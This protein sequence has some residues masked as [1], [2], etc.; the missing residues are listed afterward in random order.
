MVQA[1][2][3]GGIT[4]TG[5]Q[6]NMTGTEFHPA[7]ANHGHRQI[8]REGITS[9]GLCVWGGLHDRGHGRHNNGRNQQ[10]L[11]FCKGCGACTTTMYGLRLAGVTAVVI[12]VGEGLAHNRQPGCHCHHLWYG[13]RSSALL[14]RGSMCWGNRRVERAQHGLWA[15]NWSTESFW[16]IPVDT[17]ERRSKI[18]VKSRAVDLRA[19]KLRV[20]SSQNSGQIMS[21]KA[22][23]LGG[24]IERAN[25]AG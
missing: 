17:I 13:T 7:R 23:K 5:K 20:T 9:T 8:W 21:R 18:A 10:H 16:E 11:K 19:V 3:C 22:A 25:C 12:A 2:E 24:Q 4:S 15:I 1:Q 6:W 14:R